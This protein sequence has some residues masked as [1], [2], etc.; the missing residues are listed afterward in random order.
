MRDILDRLA[1]D[2]LGSEADEVDRMARFEGLPDLAFRLEA[3]DARPLA[4]TWV[5]HDDRSLGMVDDRARVAARRAPG[6]SS[7]V[8]AGWS[9][10]GCTS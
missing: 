1:L 9:R 10:A 5:D 7:P 2:R 8:G 6:H 3:A 4:G